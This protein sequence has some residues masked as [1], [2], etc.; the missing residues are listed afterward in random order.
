MTVNTIITDHVGIITLAEPESGN[1]LSLETA[2]HLMRAA[3]DLAANDAV[4][5]VLLTGSGRFFCVGGDIK[6][7]AESGAGLDM[8]LKGLTDALHRAMA[9]FLRMDKPV[10]VAVN[11]PAAG[12]G[13]G[14]AVVG[15][16]VLADPS[17]HFTMAYTG[18]GFS[19]DGGTSWL[20]PRLI[21]LRRA[22]EM[23]L[24]NRRLSSAEAVDWGLITRVVD[25]DLMT[26][27]NKVAQ[28][29]AKGPV[30][31]LA[32]SRALLLSSYDL[33]PEAQMEREAERV[34]AQATG[35]E[36]REGVT[37]FMEKRTPRFTA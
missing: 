19:P 16:I 21:G 15:D 12:A 30:K 14:L 26:E 17:A 7:I 11:G 10:V 35:P 5:C 37:A 31:A 23:T 24:R 22:Y 29:F 9:I 28:Q 27:A 4:R 3:E 36:G 34:R 13:L 25:G 8:Y 1:P 18:I 20:L 6:S 33:E 32:A 2:R